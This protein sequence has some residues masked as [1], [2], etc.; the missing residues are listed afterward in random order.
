MEMAPE[1]LVPDVWRGE[2]APCHN[3]EHQW[4]SIGCADCFCETSCL[5]PTL[6]IPPNIILGDA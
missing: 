4:H 5:A 3:C 6:I 2:P 1:A